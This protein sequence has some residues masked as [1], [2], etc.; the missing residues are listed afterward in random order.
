MK[1]KFFKNPETM[2]TVTKNTI[3]FYTKEELRTIETSLAI[4]MTPFKISR[5]YAEEWDR[6]QHALHQRV[7]K[8]QRD[9]NP[10]KPRKSKEKLKSRVT[11][12]EVVEQNTPV[13]QEM[14]L[15]MTEGSTFDCKPSRVTICKD[16]IRIYF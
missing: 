6:S 15:Q 1:L 16:H 4:G 5:K 9:I 10:D 12:I 13:M 14:E 7:L 8:L 2:N 11:Q 3:K